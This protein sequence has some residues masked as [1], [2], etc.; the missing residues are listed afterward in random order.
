MSHKPRKR[1]GQNFLQDQSIIHRI[2]SAIGPCLT[3]HMVEI[4]PGLGALTAGILP[5]VMKLD[6][7]EIDRNLIETL[8]KKFSGNKAFNLL[9]ADALSFDYRLLKLNQPLRIVGNLPYNISSPLLF[10]LFEQI[11]IIQDMHFM[12]QKEVVDRLTAPVGSSD[13]SRLSVMCQYY[14][15]AE[16]VLFV[17]PECFYPAPKV[18]SAVVRLTPKTPTL[19]AKKISLFTQ[20]VKTAFNYRRKTIRNSLKGTVSPETLEKLC[21]DPNRR[22]QELTIDEYVMIANTFV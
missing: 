10:H 9:N 5:L 20:V 17:P 13:Y 8:N 22:P 18:D 7:I 11:D 16:N 12:L 1:F 15:T 14:C 4:G 2:I 19:K 6:A 3:D 21:I